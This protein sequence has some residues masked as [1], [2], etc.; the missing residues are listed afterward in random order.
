MTSIIIADPAIARDETILELVQQRKV[1]QI[2]RGYF[3]TVFA[4]SESKV[5]IKVCRDSAYLAFVT[6][7]LKYQNNPW[8]PRIHSATLHYPKDDPWYLVV[9]MER[10]RKGNKHELRTCLMLL[11][12]NLQDIILFGKALNLPRSK[13]EHLAEMRR[14]LMKLFKRY[15]PDFHKGNIMFRKD[16][17][18]IIDPVVD[19]SI[20]TSLDN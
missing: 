6:A 17:A 11:D 19:G 3:G 9:E 15:G 18:V 13:L 10:L 2:G 7:I 14:V 8:F 1:R 12:G 4:K 20:T 16:Q 5:V